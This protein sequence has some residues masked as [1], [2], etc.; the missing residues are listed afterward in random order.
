MLDRKVRNIAVILAAIVTVTV[1]TAVSAAATTTAA[2][3]TTAH[4]TTVAHATTAAPSAITAPDST[5]LTCTP[6]QSSS[7]VV[8]CFQII[9]AYNYVDWMTEEACTTNSGIYYHAE[10]TGPSFTVNL[11]SGRNE[12]L[13][14]HTCNTLRLFIYGYVKPGPYTGIT[15]RYNGGNSYTNLG[16]VTKTVDP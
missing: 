16:E 9:G 10:I 2:V 14:A 12:Y 5:R 1:L 3:S 6:V 4:V 11:P 13:S 7:R 15:W 8:T